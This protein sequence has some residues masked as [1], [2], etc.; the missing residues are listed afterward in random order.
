MSDVRQTRAE[1]LRGLIAK[2]TAAG[3]ATPGLDARLLMAHALG[4]DRLQLLID[5][6]AIVSHD[7]AERLD[8]S[9]ARRLTREPVSRI[10]GERWF[11]GRAFRVTPAT[12]DPRPDSETLIEAALGL[13]REMGV[14]NHDVRL[15]DI[16]TGTGCLL[17]TLLAERQGA[18]GIGVDISPEALL[19]AAENQARLGLKAASWRC[20]SDFEPVAGE[21]FNI[22]VANPPYIPTAEI[23]RLDPEVRHFDPH[24]ALD[25]GDDGLVA[26]RRLISKF[27]EYLS[28]GWIIFEVGAGQADAVSALFCSVFA[29]AGIDLRVFNDLAGVPRC[30]AASP[31][32][33]TQP[34]QPKQT[35]WQT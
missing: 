33:V 14:A 31:R 7:A 18:A 15:L 28:N 2:F 10:V 24:L 3:I 5:G 17:L 21:T 9:A 35:P 11:Y 12:L 27:S 23:T 32:F 22:I 20:G 30:V 6:G 4:C 29:P 13:I 34:D 19:V 25:G 16:G 1:A 26:Y 8:A